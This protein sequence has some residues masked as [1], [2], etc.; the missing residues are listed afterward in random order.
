[1]KLFKMNKDLNIDKFNIQHQL[2]TCLQIINPTQ[3]SPAMY[4]TPSPACLFAVPA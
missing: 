2:K 3:T 1:M 4:N